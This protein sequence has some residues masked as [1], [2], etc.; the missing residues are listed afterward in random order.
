MLGRLTCRVTVPNCRP[1]PQFDVVDSWFGLLSKAMLK[2]SQ[3]SSRRQCD[4][5]ARVPRWGHVMQAGP[6]TRRS[7]GS[8]VSHTSPSVW[9][10]LQAAPGAIEV[11]QL[12][13]NGVIRLAYP[14]SPCSG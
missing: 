12:A 10:R 5:P 14:A 8:C 9:L 3:V 11:L 4:G 13:P 2:T 6:L 1:R 7:R